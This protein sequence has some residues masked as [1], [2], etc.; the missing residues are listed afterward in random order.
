MRGSCQ[1]TQGAWYRALQFLIHPGTVVQDATTPF[2][3]FVPV[4]LINSHGETQSFHC[5]QSNTDSLAILCRGYS[6]LGAQMGTLWKELGAI[7]MWGAV[8]WHAE[9]TE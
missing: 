4:F 8:H 5:K 9:R 6:Y 7:L 2:I 1:H 3:P